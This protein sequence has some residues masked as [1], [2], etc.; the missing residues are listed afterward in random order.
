MSYKPLFTNQSETLT[1]SQKVQISST[2]KYKPLFA[3]PE[4]VSQ[5][6][7]VQ[8]EAPVI[9]Q[10][11][12]STYATP[13][14][15]QDMNKSN[16]ISQPILSQG[17]VTDATTYIDN[18]G[19]VIPPPVE[20]S[21]AQK[22]KN[23]ESPTFE[24]IKLFA[25]DAWK[26]IQTFAQSLKEI[27][28]DVGGPA[29]GV[30]PSKSFSDIL[31]L[32]LSTAQVVLTPIQTVTEIAQKNPTLKPAADYMLRNLDALQNGGTLLSINGVG[33][34]KISG[35]NAFIEKV[36]GEMP[37]F[38]D[39]EQLKYAVQ[40]V[41]GFVTQTVVIGK[42][43]AE[44]HAGITPRST[45]IIKFA[46]GLNAQFKD[47]SINNINAFS[48]TKIDAN[49]SPDI[50][51]KA[52]NEAIFKTHPDKGGN[53]SDAARVNAAYAYLTKGEVPPINEVNPVAPKTE[54]IK[55]ETKTTNLYPETTDKVQM[56]RN[57]EDYSAKNADKLKTQYITDN[58]KGGSLAIDSDKM[59]DLFKPAGYD[60][61]NAGSFQEPASRL[62]NE[63]YQEQ[64]PVMKGQGNN[65]VLMT[66]GGPGVGKTTA[67]N[68]LQK[69]T[70][71]IIYDSSM[72]NVT[73]V[74]KRANQALK[75]G[76][77]VDIA[78]VLRD[79]V[80]AWAEG[81]LVR[82]A[83]GERHVN[84]DAFMDMTKQFPESAKKIY[85][86][87]K[88]NEKVNFIILDNKEN[89]VIDTVGPE[90][91]H[92]YAKNL[93]NN[94][95]LKDEILQQTENKVREN[96]SLKGRLP[97]IYGK[98]VVGSV[99][100]G[101][102][103][104]ATPK[105]V[106]Q[107]VKSTGITEV[108]PEVAEK[109]L[110]KKL[111]AKNKN[112]DCYDAAYKYIT[113]HNDPSLRVVH[114]MVDGQ[115]PLKGIRYDHAW[116]EKG[117]MVI[118]TSNGKNLEIPKIV[119]YAIGNIKENQLI[120]YT[121]KEAMAASLKSGRTSGWSK[122]TEIKKSDI[123][124]HG[125]TP[126]NAKKI[127]KT[128]FK[129][130]TNWRLMGDVQSPIEL[131]EG[132]HFSTDKTE[133]SMYG[134]SIIKKDLGH[135]KF[136][137]INGKEGSKI[138]KEYGYADISDPNIENTADINAALVEKAQK[139]GFDGLK[140]GDL[141]VVFDVKKLSEIKAPKKS[142]LKT[143]YKGEKDLTTGILEDLKGRSVVSK[144]YIEQRAKSSDL[145][146][147]QVEKRL[148]IQILQT[149]KTDNIPVADFAKKIKK[150]VLPLKRVSYEPTKYNRVALPKETRGDVKNYSEH[151]YNSPIKTSAGSTHFGG[152]YTSAGSIQETIDMARNSDLEGAQSVAEAFLS[153]R[154]IFSAEEAKKYKNDVK[155]GDEDVIDK[156]LDIAEKSKANKPEVGTEGYFGHTRVEDI[157]DGKTR[158]VIEVQSDLYQKGNL[159]KEMGTAFANMPS[160]VK[161]IMKE[162]FPNKSIEERQQ[163]W[164]KEQASKNSKLL[165]YND[166]TAHFR[167]IREEVKQASIDGKT[168]LQFPTGETAMKIE[169][170]SNDVKWEIVPP[171]ESVTRPGARGSRTDLTVLDSKNIKVGQRI[172]RE[173]Y[174]PDERVWI[175]TEVLKDGQF[176]A[177][178]EEK[179]NEI[180]NPDKYRGQTATPA[181]AIAN[182]SELQN[183]NELDVDIT[184][185]IYKF[186]EDTIGKYLKS[187][188]GAKEITDA[189]GV[190]W[191]E[192]KI[193][194]D[195]GTT[196]VNAFGDRI[197]IKKEPVKPAKVV[198]KLTEKPKVK[199][200]E[201]PKPPVIEKPK[202]SA[203]PAPEQ[204]TSKIAQSINQKAIE[205]GITKGFTDL[206]GYD[207]ITIKE[208][209][210]LASD[211]LS[212]IDEAR[213]VLR[214]E[215]RLPGSLRATAL[216]NAFESYIK[217]HP[218]PE[219]AAELANSPHASV[220]S[221]GGQEVRLAAERTPDS[222]TAKLIE[223]RKAREAKIGDK[224]KV[225]TSK[226]KIVDE[227]KAEQNKNNLSKD[228]LNWDKFVDSIPIC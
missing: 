193:T 35:T 126:E 191:N 50:I 227:L 17:G 31:N 175:V 180:K 52:Y 99:G 32:G 108:K 92:E 215:E 48:T 179:Y 158:R 166:P 119:Y 147:K 51:K 90:R 127:A 40:N 38:A 153:D 171:G 76:Y 91:L 124:Y 1:P 182:Y 188:F 183:T 23:A 34:M 47:Q 141:R 125:T 208:Q 98:D 185:P 72:T 133:A 54:P 27:G 123:A 199:A 228:E 7:Q 163:I 224:K 89:F 100:K 60:N 25:S 68:Q 218:N 143:A 142:S 150:E 11:K 87:L 151:V 6:T 21:K 192:I 37:D 28:K 22:I 161:A 103:G 164:L 128:G 107:P 56:E 111:D 200:I 135:L 130:G 2:S 45:E 122:P 49:S 81:V 80:K 178:T 117:D 118:D 129:I 221:Y 134:D 225:A 94:K 84:L 8:P 78:F 112:G 168:N 222:A 196:P 53:V 39:K 55:T 187:K 140:D 211:L 145:N 203:E 189:Q 4:S 41:T 59:K 71:P 198:S 132:I 165:Q 139:L 137:D 152:D 96:P 61:T 95:T 113:T 44:V 173:N 69:G 206:A 190:K 167:M 33:G 19:N 202:A 46:D 219:M 43:M 194:K 216:V 105:S 66:G 172:S 214:G 114:G 116:I 18:A 67:V 138:L 42:I 146:L 26:N 148:I 79:P 24:A 209:A 210:K 85:N 3:T 13:Q 220:A 174:V 36:F 29:G 97:E 160:E 157:K 16:K 131:T 75:N 159:E 213:K 205:A 15:V 9:P 207:T 5:S 62:T 181:E 121:Q 86:I 149:Y 204:K 74:L 156:V 57:A 70:Y 77:N 30:S 104:A 10:I 63:I 120:R 73:G 170:L 195:M 226:K 184:D 65:T 154:D 110:G 186:Y 101:T 155:N 93:K 177:V 212:N 144:K 64:L 14:Q 223:I 106:V 217:L 109:V 115:G 169:G 136:F 201:P 83:N 176:K 102:E 12:I 162:R 20:L 58:T 82:T 197:I 88:N